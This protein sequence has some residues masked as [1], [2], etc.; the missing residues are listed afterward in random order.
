[1]Y[2]VL[3]H[4]SQLSSPEVLRA[5]L[6]EGDGVRNLHANGQM[7]SNSQFNQLFHTLCYC[8]CCVLKL[9]LNGC[10]LGFIGL[11]YVC[12]MD[13][14]QKCL[15]LTQCCSRDAKSLESVNVEETPSEYDILIIHVRQF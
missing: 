3:E 15:V 12:L 6:V 9:N 4:L 1:M 11:L 10:K 7:V 14:H 2:A 8:S 13:L 5:E